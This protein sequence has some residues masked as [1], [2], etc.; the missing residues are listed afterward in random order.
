VPV[1]DGV[2]CA[3]KLVEAATG[4]GLRTSKRLGFAPP[5]GF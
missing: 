3:V 1:R 2:S 4:Y 5:A